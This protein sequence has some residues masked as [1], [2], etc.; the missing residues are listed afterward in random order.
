MFNVYGII[1]YVGAI[2]TRDNGVTA[3]EMFVS[4]FCILFAAFGAGKY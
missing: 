2:F 3:K 4:I 1:F